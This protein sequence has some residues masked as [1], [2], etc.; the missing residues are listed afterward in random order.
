M[1]IAIAVVAIAFIA[2]PNDDVDAAD[3]EAMFSVDGKEPVNWSSAE[4]QITNNSIIVVT[5]SGT[6]NEQIDIGGTDSTING[7][8]VDLKGNT[9]NIT[10]ANGNGIYVYE[11]SSLIVRDTGTSGTG[12]INISSSIRFLNNWG[13]T[14]IDSVIITQ[15]SSGSADRFIQ[16]IGKLIL[17]DCDIDIEY[18]P[19]DKYFGIANFKDIEIYGGSIKISVTVI[20]NQVEKDY[21]YPVSLTTDNVDIYTD[22][23]YGVTAVGLRGEDGSIDYEKVVVNMTGGSVNVTGSGQGFGTNASGGVYAGVTIT[24]NDV[25]VNVPNGCGMY[26]PGIG[27]YNINGGI[28]QGEQAIRIAAG[29]LNITDGAQIISNTVSNVDA[30]IVQNGSGGAP[31]AL[32]AGKTGEGYPGDLIINIDNAYISNNAGGDAVIL[33]DTCMGN[34][35]FKDNKIE[36]N[37]K[38]GT[39]TGNVQNVTSDVYTDKGD[40]VTT[41]VSPSGTSKN[42]SM[43][44]T[45]GEVIGNFVQDSGCGANLAGTMID[46]DVIQTTDDDKNQVQFNGSSISGKVTN[47]DEPVEPIASVTLNIFGSMLTYNCFNDYFELP[48]IGGSPE[49]YIFLGWSSNPNATTAQYE[50][51][52]IIREISGSIT[53]YPVLIEETSTNPPSWDDED[54]L[55]PFIPTQDSDDDS[56]T[57]VAC[58]A[59]A[60]VAA[61]MAVFLIVSYKKD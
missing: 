49:G 34:E 22:S 13:T 1:I 35:A 56:V 48:Y 55:P 54:D 20:H 32:V 10:T 3:G 21:K 59:A 60:V 18:T 5:S 47:N 14:E 42:V 17:K 37:F 30:G 46:G 19:E 45:G 25:D 16:N 7:V 39:I 53:L 58:A 6:V 28:I 29:T 33:S 44:M 61:L 2:I 38:S 9:V 27:I 23:G 11:G 36:F 50:D 26:L 51:G 12:T 57:I 52:E 43:N 40:E 31:G 15:N 4:T 24:L 8:V 41:D